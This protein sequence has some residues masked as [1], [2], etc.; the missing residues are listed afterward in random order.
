MTSV[1]M[2]IWRILIP[3]QHS[4]LSQLV[5]EY[6]LFFKESSI[7]LSM[8]GRL[9]PASASAIGPVLAAT[10]FTVHP[11]NFK[12]GV[13]HIL[14]S[15]PLKMEFLSFFCYITRIIL[16]FFCSNDKKT[17]LQMWGEKGGGQ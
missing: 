15:N 4:A 3:C 8:N 12:S 5:M 2:P 7:Y 17:G 6:T 13:H 1:E 9:F 14:V 16:L 11:F 10:C